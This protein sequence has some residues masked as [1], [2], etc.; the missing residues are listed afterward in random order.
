[1]ARCSEALL[2]SVCEQ[3]RKTTRRC[4]SCASVLALQLDHVLEG[5]DAIISPCM[6]MSTPTAAL[7]D[8]GAPAEEGKADFL[9]FTAPFDYSGIQ[10]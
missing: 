8:N 5:V 1:M 9:L 7:M 2:N 3:I 4:S 6:P 10:R